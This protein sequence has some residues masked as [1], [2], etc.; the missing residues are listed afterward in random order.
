MPKRG[1]PGST[2]GLILSRL[3]VVRPNERM[4]LRKEARCRMANIVTEAAVRRST[5]PPGVASLLHKRIARGQTDNNH[6]KAP[7]VDPCPLGVRVRNRIYGLFPSSSK[8][9]GLE[10]TSFRASVSSVKRVERFHANR[11]GLVGCVRL[12]SS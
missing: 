2:A 1:N 10:N 6:P 8:I 12:C 4:T 11:V 5:R 7:H 9:I 3:E